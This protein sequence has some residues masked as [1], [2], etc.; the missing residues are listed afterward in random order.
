MDMNIFHLLKKKND[1]I[2]INTGSISLP[3]NDIATYVIYENRE[4]IIFDINEKIVDRIKTDE[5][6]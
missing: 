6:K 4:F 1:M 5:N 3:K 2:Y